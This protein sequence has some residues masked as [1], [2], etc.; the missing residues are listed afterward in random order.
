MAEGRRASTKRRSAKEWQSL[1][2]KLAESGED[3]SQFCRRQGIYP[4]TLRWWQWRLRGATRELGR[5]P[6]PAPAA[7]ELIRS[8]FTELRVLEKAAA[9]VAADF[10]ELR[11]PDGLTL[12]IPPEF[13]AAALRRLLMVLEVAGC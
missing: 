3:L 4:P 5:P 8:R 1:V 6:H 12:A 2:S 13:D 10:F 7:A 9:A 11:W